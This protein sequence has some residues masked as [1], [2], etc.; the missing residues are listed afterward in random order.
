M[1]AQRLTLSPFRYPYF[2]T[3]RSCK[4]A[5]KMSRTLLAVR[6]CATS[7]SN[8][9]SLSL[10]HT[11]VWQTHSSLPG[12]P[13]NL[14]SWIW[15]RHTVFTAPKAHTNNTLNCTLTAW[16]G[17]Q[18]ECLHLFPHI[19]Q[20]CLT[21]PFRRDTHTCLCNLQFCNARYQP[22]RLQLRPKMADTVRRTPSIPLG[23]NTNITISL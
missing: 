5:F 7:C 19:R 10:K 21:T 13:H 9:I 4:S 18:W 3:D 6:E 15:S 11:P 20:L 8:Y 14:H 23:T 2:E 16:R 22:L 17:A 1:T 12:V